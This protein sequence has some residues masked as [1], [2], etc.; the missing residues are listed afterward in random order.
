ME[1]HL[2]VARGLY[3]T[4][5]EQSMDPGLSLLRLTVGAILNHLEAGQMH[6]HQI[7]FADKEPL[8]TTYPYLEAG[9]QEQP[10][11]EINLSPAI[12]RLEGTSDTSTISYSWSSLANQAGTLPLSVRQAIAALYSLQPHLGN[13]QAEVTLSIR[14]PKASTPPDGSA[15]PSTEGQAS[16]ASGQ[17]GTDAR[18]GSSSQAGRECSH[19]FVTMALHVG[20][21]GRNLVCLKCGERHYM[22]YTVRETPT[23]TEGREGEK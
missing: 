4:P 1:D 17:P 7:K 3:E 23:P 18:P 11:S 19:E 6:Q 21:G 5:L 20:I 14:I 12:V 22:T 13:P 9:Q 16:S 2:Q 10:A 8:K 15:S